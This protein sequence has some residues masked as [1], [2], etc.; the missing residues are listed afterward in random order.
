MK[1][2]EGSWSCTGQNGRLKRRKT[3]K[4]ERIKKEEEIRAE[5]KHG[6]TRAARSNVNSDLGYKNIF[7]GCKKEKKEEKKKKIEIGFGL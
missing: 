6:S 4:K 7:C 2:K 3:K 1:K 5:E